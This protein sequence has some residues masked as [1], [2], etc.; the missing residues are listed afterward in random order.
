MFLGTNAIDLGMIIRAPNDFKLRDVL[1]V[2]EKAQ[3][4]VLD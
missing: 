3:F 1:V 4:L 2:S